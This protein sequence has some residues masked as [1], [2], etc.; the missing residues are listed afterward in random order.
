MIINIGRFESNKCNLSDIYSLFLELRSKWATNSKLIDIVDKRWAFLH[1][2]SMG[3]AYFL[4]PQYKAGCLMINTDIVDT[5][6]QLKVFIL[7]KKKYNISVEDLNSEINLFI[8]DVAAPNQDLAAFY[9][10]NEPMCYWNLIGKAKFPILFKVASIVFSIP[11]SQAASERV[12]SIFNFIHSKLRNRLSAKKTIKL[13]SLY[14]HANFVKDELNLIKIMQG[15][16]DDS[17]N[18]TDDDLDTMN[19]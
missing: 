10:D 5:L 6:K 3:F 16:E 14:A 19:E 2:E 12:W 7:E 17:G 15:L 18:T 11:C 8:S 9:K 4:N 13:V 1:T